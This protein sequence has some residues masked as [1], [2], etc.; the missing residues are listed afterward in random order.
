MSKP[1]EANDAKPHAGGGRGALKVTTANV[2]QIRPSLTDI[3]IDSVCYDGQQQVRIVGTIIY[4]SGARH[5]LGRF[6]RP[7]WRQWPGRYDVGD[8]AQGEAGRSDHY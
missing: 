8:R 2:W 1:L 5:A 4:L 7:G 3:W 6:R